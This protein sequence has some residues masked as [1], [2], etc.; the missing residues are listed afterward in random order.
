MTWDWIKQTLADIWAP[1]DDD[2][3]TQ[4]DRAAHR[5]R[6]EIAKA[7]LRGPRLAVVN[8]APSRDAFVTWRD[9]P[10]TQFVFAALRAAAAEQKTAWDDV[11]WHGG[12]ADANALA[13]F[14]TRADAYESLEAGTYEDFCRWA[15]VEPEKLTDEGNNAA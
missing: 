12:T 15:N 6:V 8:R 13:E 2:F 7:E 1:Q 14:R 4:D 3:W 9:S 11:A 10:V 5:A